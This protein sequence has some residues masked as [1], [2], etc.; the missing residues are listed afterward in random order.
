MMPSQEQDIRV[1]SIKFHQR[2]STLF[3]RLLHGLS[4]KQVSRPYYN[5]IN[6]GQYMHYKWKGT[7]GWYSP[8]GER[9]RM[10]AR[11]PGAS[12]AGTEQQQVRSY[13]PHLSLGQH[14]GQIYSALLISLE[15]DEAASCCFP[16]NISR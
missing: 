11:Y 4:I 3:T 7:P 13:F 16:N 2:A 9:D 8:S 6:T 14:V 5:T 12:T 1:S 10:R 15:V